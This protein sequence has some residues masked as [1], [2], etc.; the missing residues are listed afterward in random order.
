MAIGI[1]TKEILRQYQSKS[2]R[3][4]EDRKA[5]YKFLEEEVFQLR[6]FKN[7]VNETARSLDISYIIAYEVLTNHLTDVLFELDRGIEFKRKKIK[8]NMFSYFSLF[9]G[10]MENLKENKMFIKF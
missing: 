5:V 4:F 3:K 7:N 9:V 8:I 10:F 2:V 1:K 6:D